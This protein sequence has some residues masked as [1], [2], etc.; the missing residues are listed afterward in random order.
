MKKNKLLAVLALTTFSLGL[1]AS[2]GGTAAE[3][4]TNQEIVEAVMKDSSILVSNKT[5]P[6]RPT[7]YP[8]AYNELEAITGGYLKA[9][10]EFKYLSDSGN[11]HN[12]SL[13]W[14]FDSEKIRAKD[15][16]EEKYK[17]LKP[18]YDNIEKDKEIVTT[19]KGKATYNNAVAE[20]TYDIHI[21]N[22]KAYITIAELGDHLNETYAVQGYVTGIIDKTDESGN[23]YGIYV[24]DGDHGMM[25]YKPSK[26]V[27]SKLKIGDAIEVL[28]EISEYNGTKQL[29]KASISKLADAEIRQGVQKANIPELEFKADIRDDRFASMFKMTGAKVIDCAIQSDYY[30]GKETPNAWVKGVVNYKGEEII[31]SS[32]RYNA[33]YED[34]IKFFNMLK[35]AKDSNGAKTLNYTAPIASITYADG[36]KDGNTVKKYT[37]GFTFIDTSFVEIADKAYVDS[38]SIALS[39]TKTKL[40]IGST[41]ELTTKFNNTTETEATFTSS[42]ETIA[43]VSET[44]KVTAVAPGTVA[45]T[46]TGKTNTDVKG[47][48]YITV[49][50][51]MK[52]SEVY[53]AEK[54]DTVS[55]NGIVTGSGNNGIYVGD[56][57][58]GIFIYRGVLKGYGIGDKVNVT[59]EVDLYKG[60]FQI[61][62]ATVK[63][64]EKADV[65]EPVVLEI[66]DNLNDVDGKDTGRK[67]L[68]S[69]KIKSTDLSHNADRN[70]DTVTL[71]ILLADGKT[72]VEVRADSRYSTKEDFAEISALTKD[73]DVKLNGFI[74]YFNG[75]LN[76]LP[77]NADGLQIVAPSVVK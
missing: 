48:I 41:V 71:Q 30:K 32:D 74:S 52:L 55:F 40:T 18:I 29:N 20:A 17:E 1:A 42:D 33:D 45:I 47:K 54:K 49:L 24:Q 72:E 51:P 12:V 76:T 16:T 13:E 53:G 77:T 11:E 14:T 60:L 70:Y 7:S 50:E 10:T 67:V 15:Y 6:M 31:I 39:A 61:K 28:G 69:G 58:T 56:G 23:P 57:E 4:M 27:V 26:S 46:A 9:T 64:I 36:E 75:K 34:K 3:T 68:L 35:E 25:V 8:T 73:S 5:V 44:G 21:V 37:E 59:G 63:K 65:S 43:T 66:K 19:I 38:P 22:N 2:C 62:N